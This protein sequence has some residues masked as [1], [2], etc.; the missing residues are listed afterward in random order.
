MWRMCLAEAGDADMH[1]ALRGDLRKKGVLVPRRFLQIL[2]REETPDYENGSGRG[3]L[4]ESVVDPGN[5]LS[6]RVMVNR[7]WQWHFGKALVRTPSNFGVLGEPP[8]T[9]NCL[10]G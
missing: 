6:A 1:V 10:I 2:N 4:A 3:E 7:V 5:P 9:L 8:R